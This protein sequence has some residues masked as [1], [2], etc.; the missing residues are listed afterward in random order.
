MPYCVRSDNKM[1]TKYLYNQDIQYFKLGFNNIFA[2]SDITI[3]LRD[4]ILA[5]TGKRI[6][7]LTLE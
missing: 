3:S 5:E 1:E 4:Q 7:G 6:W 2:I